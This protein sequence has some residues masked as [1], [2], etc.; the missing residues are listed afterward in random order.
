M[1]RVLRDRGQS[2]HVHVVSNP[3]FLK[4]GKAVTDFVRPDRIVVGSDSPQGDAKMRSLYSYFIRNGHPYLSMDVRS[5]EMSKYAANVMLATRISL[6]NELAH[7]CERVGADIME[8][9][10]GVGSDVRIGMQFLYPG[11][12]FGGS[13]FPKDVAALSR[14]AEESDCPADI[15]DAVARVN[16]Y[17]KLSMANRVVAHFGGDLRDRTI[18]VWGLAFKP[19]TDDVRE[20]PALTVV[21]RLMDAGAL[22]RA[23]DPEATENARAALGGD[24]RVQFAPSMYEALDGADALVL[25]TEWPMFRKPNFERMKRLLK[26]PVVFDGRNQYELSDMRD[27]GFTYYCVGRG[28]V[29]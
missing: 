28:M 9:R 22:V 27:L 10:R 25:V 4:E 2:Y 7:I 19:Q 12:G 17:Q 26:S 16:R 13:C 18:A 6:M 1:A 11:V 14:M 5:S 3:E 23:Y 8:V 29:G 15:L 21:R 20:A 24:T